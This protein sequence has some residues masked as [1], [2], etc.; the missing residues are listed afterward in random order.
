MH[1]AP[2]GSPRQPRTAQSRASEPR[3]GDRFQFDETADY[4]RLKLANIVDE[5]TRDALVMG[6]PIQGDRRAPCSPPTTRRRTWRAGLLA[7]GHSPELTANALRDW[8][9]V[10]RSGN[11]LH[12]TRLA[13]EEPVGRVVQRPVERRASERRGVRHLGRGEGTGRRLENRVQHLPPTFLIEGH[14]TLS[15]SGGA[16]KTDTNRHAQS[17]WFRKWGP[18]NTF[19]PHSSLGYLAPCR[20]AER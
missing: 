16:G 10:L 13:L 2:P 5:F 3:L 17:G 1:Q 12:R 7:D 6:N 8:S 19:R 11:Q 14:M 20:F 4:R 15:S 9:P 18:D